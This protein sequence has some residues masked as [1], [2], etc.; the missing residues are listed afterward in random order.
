MSKRSQLLKQINIGA[1][2]GAFR[3]LGSFLTF[4]LTFAN[5]FLLLMSWYMLVNP[6]LQKRGIIVPLFVVLLITVALF[7]AAL[8]MEHKF[9]LPSYFTYWNRQWWNHGN[10]LPGKLDEIQKQLNRIEEAM[11]KE[12]IREDKGEW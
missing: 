10:A 11:S 2:W 5:F 8:L 3:N 7:I 6:E 12:K 1:W 4:Y 9:T